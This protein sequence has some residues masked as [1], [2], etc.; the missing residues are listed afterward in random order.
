MTQ[1]PE[2]LRR[3]SETGDRCGTEAGAVLRAAVHHHP[4]GTQGGARGTAYRGVD[5]GNRTAEHWDGAELA[6]HGVPEGLQPDS[7]P[8]PRLPA[9][10]AGLTDPAATGRTRT[11]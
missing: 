11:G 8:L 7:A 9:R 6:S 3:G 2:T 5:E 1:Q 10:A 4:S